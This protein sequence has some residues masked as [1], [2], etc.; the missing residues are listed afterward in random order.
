MDN[1]SLARYAWLSV[2]AALATIGLK[3]AAYLLTGSVGLL[4]DAL[5]SGVNLLGALMTWAMLTVAALP[6]DE[7]HP[8]GHSKAEYFSSGFEG[9]L[10][11]L[12]AISIGVVA[13]QRLLAP[14][15]LE[16][17]VTGLMVS[18]GATIINLGVGVILLRAGRHHHSISL[19]ADALH[20]LTDV[21]TSVAVIVGVGLVA[22]SGWLW[23]DPVLALGVAVHI[24]WTGYRLVR[25][26]VSG[27]M[28]SALPAAQH[29]AVVKVLEKH[30]AEGIQYHALRT[31]RAAARQFI[32][33]HILVPGEWTVSRGHELL[34]RIEGDIRAVLT[35]AVVFTHLEPL[36]EA[37]SFADLELDRRER[38]AV[39]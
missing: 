13:V 17:T 20:L 9:T 27:L 5:E 11:L 15:P 8:Y 12:A 23:L 33:V 21:W 2:A 35:N 16:Q 10:I 14:Q 4:S 37:S 38:S 19:E 29:E 22:I 6:P 24:L 31:R 1:P 26:S 3:T 39:P 28:D 25:R 36:E 32:S 18:A 30:K 7:E 34:D